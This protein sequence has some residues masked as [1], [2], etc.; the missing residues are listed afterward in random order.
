MVTEFGGQGHVVHLIHGIRTHAA[1]QERVTAM[2]E[3][4]GGVRVFSTRY[5][6]FDL[7]SFLLPGPTR[8][9]PIKKTLKDLLDAARVAKST[10]SKL[11]VIAHSYGT[12]AIHEI[13]AE[14]PAIDID[15]LILC[16]AIK[17][18][19][20]NWQAVQ[21]ASVKGTL[22]NDY[23][24][25]DVWPVIAASITWGYGNGG[26]YGI[27]HPFDDRRHPFSHSDFFDEDFVRKFWL[28]FFQSGTVTPTAY[29]S[30]PINPWWF[31]FLDLPWRWVIAAGLAA[32][33][34]WLAISLL[35]QK[36]ILPPPTENEI[37]LG[38]NGQPLTG[39][40]YFEERQGRS[41]EDGVFRVRGTAALPA[42]SGL[43]RGTLMRATSTARVREEPTKH[44]EYLGA[45]KA[46]Q[47][48]SIEEKPSNPTPNL[49]SAT[50]GGWVLVRAV[51]CPS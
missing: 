48:A 44:S 18:Q 27:G 46:G 23:G 4:V 35:S 6:K 33:C 7:L 28:P 13:L 11:T 9:P 21:R 20:C 2:L 16:G 45:F 31:R 39:F 37:S 50:S 3:D 49:T 29:R 51:K 41:T 38:A 40:V 32:L 34:F 19:E 26:T 22:I 12:H 15:N 42:Y 17:G 10:G 14:N 25:K 24:T 1:W 8:L 43:D 5:G 30:Y 36:N 47:C